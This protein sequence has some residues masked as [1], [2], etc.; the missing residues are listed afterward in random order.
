MRDIIAQSR[1]SCVS[2]LTGLH[3]KVT[4]CCL[5]LTVDLRQRLLTMVLIGHGPIAKLFITLSNG[6]YNLD[7]SDALFIVT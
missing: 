3:F 4:I 7:R 1:C 5:T 2:M 6:N